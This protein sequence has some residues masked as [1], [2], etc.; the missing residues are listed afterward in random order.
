MT[1]K[2][3]LV[4]ADGERVWVPVDGEHQSAQFERPLGAKKISLPMPLVFEDS[5]DTFLSPSERDRLINTRNEGLVE[6]SKWRT[7]KRE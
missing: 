3:M 6:R 5:I 4:I 7:K 2:V 1:N